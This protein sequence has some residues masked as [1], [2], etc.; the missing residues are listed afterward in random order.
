[1]P[2]DGGRKSALTDNPRLKRG[3][4]LRNREQPVFSPNGRKIVYSQFRGGAN[5]LVVMKVDGSRKHVILGGR[6]GSR[7]RSTGERTR[8]LPDGDAA[9]GPELLRGA[10]DRR[11][12]T[13]SSPRSRAGAS[14][15]TVTPTPIHNR[16]VVTL[17]GA[18]TRCAG[19]RRA[20]PRACVERI[21][22]RRA[23]GRAPADRR[24]RRLPGRLR[25]T[26]TSRATRHGRLALRAAEAIADARGAGLPLRRARARATERRERA[27]FRR[28]G[29]ASCARRMR[30]GRARARPRA[31]ARRTRPPA[32]RWSPRGR[33][34]PPS[35]SSST[36][37]TLEIARAVAAELR[38]SRR[39]AAG[40]AGDRRSTST[41]GA[42]VST[43]VHDPVAVPLGDVIER[44]P[45]ARRPSTARGRSRPRSSGSCPRRRSPA[46]RRRPDARLR[47]GPPRDRAPARDGG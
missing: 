47:P 36:P 7:T 23:R 32:R 41:G 5:D 13:R 15:S 28:G 27:F 25:S 29:P 38:E 8:S 1:M 31:A 46:S 19:A 24:A 20:A 40:R 14:C 12:S 30:D 3:E 43:N 42:Q 18:P 6:P 16:T 33:R 2:I 37:P 45:R 44:G 10:D 22:M 17:A 9:R 34:W 26:T 35:T 11:R 4:P 21:D 39:R